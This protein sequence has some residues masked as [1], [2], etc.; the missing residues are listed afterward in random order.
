MLGHAAQI[1]A[2]PVEAPSAHPPFPLKARAA[3]HGA[4]SEGAV[5]SNDPPHAEFVAEFL[6][7]TE[8]V[9]ND[10]LPEGKQKFTR[11]FMRKVETGDVG[12]IKDTLSG[13]RALADFG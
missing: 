6:R 12:A 11:D 9:G 5:S 1:G 2:T 4:T 8:L 7:L 10:L 3:E 13:L